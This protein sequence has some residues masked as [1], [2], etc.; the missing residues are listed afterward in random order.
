[1]IWLLLYS[2]EATP[3]SFFTGID[4]K[5][6]AWGNTIIQCDLPCDLFISVSFF[7]PF[8]LLRVRHLI[9]VDP[10]GFEPVPPEGMASLGCP[11]WLEMI[12]G[13]AS[14]FNPLAVV[15]ATGPWG[16]GQCGARK[17]ARTQKTQTG[18]EDISFSLDLYLLLLFCRSKVNQSSP[19][20]LQE[21][22]QGAFSG[23][24]HYGIHLS[25]QCSDS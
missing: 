7:H 13:M 12:V 11:R 20:R 17:D 9:L 3:L 15:R 2:Y 25:L 22:L 19:T 18:Y 1:M 10:W 14:F 8:R 24:Y 5:K 23:W 21:E 6:E 4:R 16:K